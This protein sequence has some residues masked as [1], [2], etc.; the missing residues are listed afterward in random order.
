MAVE[1]TAVEAA[2][3][4]GKPVPDGLPIE[5]GDSSVMLMHLG[6]GRGGEGE[7]VDVA[8]L[9]HPVFVAASAPAAR[10]A[11]GDPGEVGLAALAGGGYEGPSRQGG[12]LRPAVGRASG[13]G[14][15][16]PPR[17]RGVAP[18]W[19]GGGHPDD[20]AELAAVQAEFVERARVQRLGQQKHFKK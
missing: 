15:G 5:V 8:S 19:S 18:L 13:D 4:D 16:R 17:A 20:A 10:A 7:G 3:S 11:F 14:V 1:E 6:P 2:M 12:T 9:L